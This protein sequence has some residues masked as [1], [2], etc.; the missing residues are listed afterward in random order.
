MIMKRVLVTTLAILSF[1][2]L[3]V[4]L[5]GDLDLTFNGTGISQIGFDEGDDRGFATAIQVGGKI[6]VAGRVFNS[7]NYDFGVARYNPDGSL[8]STF[9]SDGFV[10]T[11]IFTDDEAR[12]VAIQTDGKI[13]VAGYT[14]NGSLIQIAVV[15][16]NIDGT[17]DDTF[18]GDGIATAV[19]GGI[20]FGSSVTIDSN[21]KILV[22]AT[23]FFSGEYNFAVF[24]FNPDGSLDT[25]FDFDGIA[26]TDITPTQND[27]VSSIAIQPDGRIVA[28]GNNDTSFVVVRYMANGSLDTSFDGDGIL[29]TSISN[30]GSSSVANS[31]VIDTFGVDQKIVVTGYTFNSGTGFDI[32]VARYNLNGSLDGSFDSDGIVVTSI[33]NGAD[34][35]YSGVI[36]QSN[37]K[38]VVAGSSRRTVGGNSIR[39]FAAI[40]YE[41]DGSLD[42][43]FDGDGI[44][45]TPIETG[46]AQ[47]R[48]IAF[49]SGGKLLLAGHSSKTSEQDA[50]DNFTLVQ[51]NADGTLDT[52]FDADGKVI[53]PWNFNPSTA[54][55]IAV[56]SDG[57][58]IVVGT[59]L[60]G[61]NND[62]A[63]VRFNTNGT[64]D[65]TFNFSGK[66]RTNFGG[67]DAAFAVAI[68]TDGKILVAGSTLN[69]LSDSDFA[70]ARYNAN[71]SLDT[72]FGL[73]GLVR[74]P[75]SSRQDEIHSIAVQTDGKIIVAGYTG[76]TSTDY[77]FAVVRYDSNGTLDA[78]FDFDG[79]V[80]TSVGTVPSTSNFDFA[81]SVAIQTDGKI[82]VAGDSFNGSNFDFGLV[83]YNSDGSLDNSFDTDGKLTTA[84]S[85]E[86]DQ[87]NS[88][89]IQTDGKIIVVG[90]SSLFPVN[91]GFAIVR[92]NTNGSLDT[93]FSFDGKDTQA[94]G[95][96]NAGAFT[97]AIQ[98]DGKILVGGYATIGANKVFAIIRYKT[99][100]DLGRPSG[101]DSGNF[102]DDDGIVTV[103]VSSGDDIVYG[104][105]IDSQGRVVIVGES[106]GSFGII[107]LQGLAPTAASVSISGRVLTTNSRG[108]MNASVSLTDSNG[109]ARTVRTNSFG[110]YRFN[111]IESG[112][113]VVIAVRSKRYQYQS[114][115]V[116]VN[117]NLS[118]IDFVPISVNSNQK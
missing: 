53:T 52:T 73:G 104:M 25:A 68:Q 29:T 66:L 78:S 38:I 92:Y 98:A 47:A 37:G 20:S 69:G 116:S 4:A 35:G 5:P 81:N 87:A 111:E 7:Q 63:V 83:R 114:Q 62:F 65:T 85:S 55:G 21:D 72:G 97:S 33:G 61:S 113:T 112:Q 67:N 80:T 14:S 89:S 70:V 110:Y 88:L 76:N 117:E 58:L 39:D 59:A 64:L 41:D 93:S 6:V 91:T 79:K 94:V 77:D 40:R 16:Y 36:Q 10:N 13:V 84:V 28:V 17:L 90:Q 49:V 102:W 30:I 74:T 27:N 56:Q 19:L 44:V 100:G 107:R 23:A 103:D 22:A 26:T 50:Q 115:V 34:F 82:V 54:R 31:V 60:N 95:V 15:R 71:G 1:A 106:N 12:S 96:E 43:S 9:D 86:T 105:K 2:V 57:K 46:D 75:L 101:E 24:R 32:A 48:A 99:D 45:T 51:Y 42:A 109:I 11:N 18:N 108:L 3:A 118:D 8:D